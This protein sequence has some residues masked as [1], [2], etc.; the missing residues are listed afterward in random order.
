MPSVLIQEVQMD[1]QNGLTRERIAEYAS[2]FLTKQSGFDVVIPAELDEFGLSKYHF[3]LAKDG[4]AT[5]IWY[6][7]REYRDPITGKDTTGRFRRIFR[8][9]GKQTMEMI[10]I[11]CT[12]EGLKL[13][14][15]ETLGLRIGYSDSGYLRAR[16]PMEIIE[17]TSM[18][19]GVKF[20]EALKDFLPDVD[21]SSEGQQMRD[22][23]FPPQI[24]N[25]PGE[26][27]VQASEQAD[28]T[29][30]LAKRKAQEKAK[31]AAEAKAKAEADAKSKADAENIQ[32][33]LKAQAEADA[34]SKK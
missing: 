19:A 24:Q 5:F 21:D 20:E 29:A 10:Q 13:P 16:W 26:M 6:A 9:T 18:E 25:Q 15:R 3:R 27:E 17:N 31:A 32:A 22:Q 4:G 12:T 14:S 7:D 30:D 11:L 8:L 34:K 23:N 33:K 28:K 2:K 1:Y